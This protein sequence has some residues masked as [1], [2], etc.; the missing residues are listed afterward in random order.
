[1]HE[2]IIKALDQVGADLTGAAKSDA[3]WTSAVKQSLVMLGKKKGC[4]CCASEVPAAEHDKWLYDVCWLRYAE[5]EIV[6]LDLAA[7]SKWLGPT[8]VL[9]DFQ[10]LCQ[11]RAR[12]RVMIFQARSE[13]ERRELCARLAR[14]AR[15][16]RQSEAGDQYLLSCWIEAEGA[17]KFVHELLTV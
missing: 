16:F 7:E 9:K 3:E 1:M 17:Y 11:T 10:K 4:D 12:L 6:D 14:Q 13:P 2:D 5:D 8:Y 15:A